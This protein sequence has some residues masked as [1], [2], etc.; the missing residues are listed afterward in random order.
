MTIKGIRSVDV[1][2]NSIVNIDSNILLHHLEHTVI[3]QMGQF[4]EPDSVL[5]LDNWSG[6]DKNRIETLCH[7]AKIVVIFLPPY[8]YDFSPIEPVFH[9]S[10]HHMQVVHGQ[11]GDELIFSMKEF[12]RQSLITAITPTQACNLFTHCWIEVSAQERTWANSAI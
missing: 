2:D 4:P 5:I 9:I 7:P 11:Q 3:P 10:K 12:F 6:H 1:I 8:S